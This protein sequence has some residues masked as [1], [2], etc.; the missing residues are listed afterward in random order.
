MR[1]HSFGSRAAVKVFGFYLLLFFSF[2]VFANTRKVFAQKVSQSRGVAS[3]MSEIANIKNYKYGPH[4]RNVFDFY[5]SSPKS[6]VKRQLREIGVSDSVSNTSCP[7][8]VC[9]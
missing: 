1:R 7:D 6:S 5:R 9:P 8:S 4:E 2:S 3:Q